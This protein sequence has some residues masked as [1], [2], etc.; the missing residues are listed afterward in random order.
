ERLSPVF[1]SS[2]VVLH[3]AARAIA[4][5]ATQMIRLGFIEMPPMPACNDVS[6]PLY[7]GERQMDLLLRSRGDRL[8]VA[9]AL[10]VGRL[11]DRVLELHLAGLDDP[12]QSVIHRLHPL[13]LPRL[14]DRGEHLGVRL[15]DDVRQGRVLEQ[16][17][18]NR[19]SPF[20]VCRP[21]QKMRDHAGL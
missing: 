8:R 13:L 11:G 7:A 5:N 14:D 19:D 4:E 9:K 12:Q 21:E 15:T 18:V 6:V 2:L 10:L 16:Y 17:F 1:T 20:A 3:P